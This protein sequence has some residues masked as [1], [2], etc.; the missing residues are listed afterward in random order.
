MPDEAKK[1]E[2]KAPDAVKVD[3]PAA[4]Q[5]GPEVTSEVTKK[6]ETKIEDA[7][8]PE[9]ETPKV[10]VLRRNKPKIVLKEATATS[11]EVDA[12]EIDPDG[13]YAPNSTAATTAAEMKAGAA[14][15]AKYQAEVERVRGKN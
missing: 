5:A 1:P 13:D 4:P 14:A 6:F 3:A 2:D 11:P 9:P 10:V 8:M 12:Q 15:L 7:P